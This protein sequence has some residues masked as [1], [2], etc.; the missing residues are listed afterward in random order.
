MAPANELIGV[1]S[2]GAGYYSTFSD[3]FLVF[4]PDGT[5]RMAFLTVASA[6][7]D[8]F[9]WVIVQPGVIDLIGER[10]LESLNDEGSTETPSDFRFSNVAFTVSEEERPPGTDQRMLVLRIDLPLPYPSELGLEDREWASRE[11]ASREWAS[12]EWAR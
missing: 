7:I 6:S 5:G 2:A 9:R 12:R 4:R 3:E 1:W 10:C 8:T 11:W